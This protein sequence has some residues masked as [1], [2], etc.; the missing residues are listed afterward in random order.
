[1]SRHAA[2]ELRSSSK[3][4]NC[5]VLLEPGCDDCLRLRHVNGIHIA[6]D[7]GSSESDS[8]KGSGSKP[9]GKMG[10]AARVLLEEHGLSPDDV[11]PSG[12]QDIITK[13]ALPSSASMC[14]YIA[15]PAT[16]LK[17]AVCTSQC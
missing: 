2:G 11:I 9:S 15:K 16:I 7:A 10:P 3:F 14:W 5:S 6:F 13:G 17:I 12:P 1:M 4:R 8:S